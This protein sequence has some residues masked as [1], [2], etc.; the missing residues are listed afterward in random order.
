M[1]RTVHERVRHRRDGAT[2]EAIDAPLTSDTRKR[3]N[4][5]FK[6]RKYGGKPLITGLTKRSHFMVTDTFCLFSDRRKRQL[7]EKVNKKINKMPNLYL[8][9][10]CGR[11]TRCGGPEALIQRHQNATMFT[12]VTRG[13]T[14]RFSGTFSLRAKLFCNRAPA[15]TALFSL[16]RPRSAASRRKKRRARPPRRKRR[17]TVVLCYS[18][19]R[20]VQGSVRTHLNGTGAGPPGRANARRGSKP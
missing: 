13:N 7:Y 6:K 5:S 11:P 15:K 10:L 4:R 14:G 1:S 12:G 16:K 8:L 9:L 19:L 20:T 17:K 18:F 3:E 2:A